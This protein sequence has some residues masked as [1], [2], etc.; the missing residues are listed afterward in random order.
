MAWVAEVYEIWDGTQWQALTGVHVT[1]DT[2]IS[3]GLQD[4]AA[5]VDPGECSF[6]LDNRAGRYSPRNPESDLYGLIGRNTPLRMSVTYPTPYLRVPDVS[7]ARAR[8]ASSS[9]LN[10]AGDIDVRIELALDRLP[11]QSSTTF[12]GTTQEIIGRYNATS[13]ARMWVLMINEWGGVRF[14]WSVDGTSGGNVEATSTVALPFVS[15]H[16]VA[17]RVALDVNNGSSGHTAYFY[18]AD[19]LAGPWVPLGQPVTG[20]G[21]TS[22]NTSGSADLELADITAGLGFTRGAGAYFALELRSGIG[23]TVLASADFTTQAVGAT[24]FVDAQS[25]T[26]TILGGAECTE[27]YPLFHG[28]IPSWPSRRDPSGNAVWVEI[29]AAGILRRYSK[30]T[31]ALQSALA[32]RVPSFSPLGYWPMEE[33]SSD[34]RNRRAYSPVD[35]VAPMTTRGLSWAADDTLPGS[36]ALPTIADGS[37]WEVSFPKPDGTTT[38]WQVELV[39]RM[40]EV[41]AS[42]RSLLWITGSGTVRLWRI[43]FG[44]PGSQTLTCQVTGTDSGGTTIVDVSI[45]LGSNVVDAWLRLRFTAVQ[46]GGSVDWQIL[47]ENVGGTAGQFSDTYVGSVGRPT[48]ASSP[49]EYHADMAGVSLGHVA[50]FVPRQLTAFDGADDGW[51]GETAVARMRRLAEEE[52]FPIS[53]LGQESRST[54]MGPQRPAALLTLFQECADADGGILSEVRGALALQYRPRDARYNQRPALELDYSAGE[55]TPPLAPEDD[56]LPTLNDIKL[57]RPG[58]SSARAVQRTGP[59]SIQPPPAGVGLYD[60][61]QT[62]NVD[63]DEQLEPIAHWRLHL[64]TWDGLRFPVVTLNMANPRMAGLIRDVLHL[65]VGDRVIIDRAPDDLPPEAIDVIAQG[66]GHTINDPLWLTTLTCSPAGP[67]TT[68]TVADASPSVDDPPHKAGGASSTLAAGITS[69]QTSL[70]VATSSGPLWTTTDLPVR[71]VIGG[72]EMDATAI[73]GASSPQTFTVTRSVNGVVKTHAAGA[74]VTLAA[75]AIVAL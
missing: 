30:G 34:Q 20:S 1:Q 69:S 18:T 56:D 27:D 38:E 41:P 46:D 59:L 49:T 33:E 14:R 5:V 39:Y 75:P 51:A 64:G 6:H 10:I 44:P 26:W 24:S 57:S 35:G 3:G 15:G 11:A 67:W 73:T 29:E 72:E 58:G 36:A 68:A 65:Q 63:Q 17:L 13:D 47:W 54:P 7:G 40:P 60:E 28:E 16:R 22:I 50:G 37:S 70:S 12:A 4:G 9:G 71:I 52:Q 74:A 66:Y 19:S 2:E 25:N 48:A 61:A 62:A 31:K 43:L 21:T 32:R 45:A 8:V 53:V 23:G 55:I 42:N